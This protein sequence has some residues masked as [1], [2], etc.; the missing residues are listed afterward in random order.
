MPDNNRKGT[1]KV[2]LVLPVS[3][4]NELSRRAALRE[5]NR[6]RKI[7]DLPGLRWWG[8]RWQDILRAGLQ[9]WID[10][11]APAWTDKGPKTPPKRRT[12]RRG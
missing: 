1:R 2:T 11:T 9:Q 3:V 8:L 7:L 6:D 5:L 10:E 12:V 4:I